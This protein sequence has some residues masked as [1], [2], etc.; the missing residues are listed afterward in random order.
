MDERGGWRLCNGR[1]GTFLDWV[2]VLAIIVVCGALLSRAIATSW[3]RQGLPPWMVA[4]ERW[5]K[6]Q[7]YEWGLWWKYHGH[8]RETDTNTRGA[9]HATTTLRVHAD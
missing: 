8:G 3:S 9:D 2:G 6:R 5:E 7:R 1:R 4:Y